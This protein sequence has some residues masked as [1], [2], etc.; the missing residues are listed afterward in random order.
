[1]VLEWRR[2]K[3]AWVERQEQ[4]HEGISQAAYA[5]W[6][7]SKE[8]SARVRQ[9]RTKA[10]A[11]ERDGAEIETHTFVH[12]GVETRVHRVTAPEGLCWSM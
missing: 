11:R 4:F 3:W 2:A 9:E 10:A 6:P 7:V 12:H 1:M 5:Y 8:I